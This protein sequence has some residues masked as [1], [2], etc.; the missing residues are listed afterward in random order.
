MND[1]LVC[2]DSRYEAIPLSHPSGQVGHLR[3]LLSACQGAQLGHT[4]HLARGT[5]RHT[6]VQTTYGVLQQIKVNSVSSI[7]SFIFN[8]S[9]RNIHRII[10]TVA[11]YVHRSEFYMNLMNIHFLLCF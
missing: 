7:E 8:V 6:L 4:V 11:Y 3:L 1:A 2:K 10:F 5:D 9:Q